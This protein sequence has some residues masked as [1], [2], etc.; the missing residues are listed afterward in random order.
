MTAVPKSDTSN[1]ERIV[2]SPPLDVVAGGDDVSYNLNGQKLGRK[3]RD[4]R[5]RILAACIQVLEDESDEQ[6][7]MSAVA[8][9]AQ[10]RMTSLYNYFADITELLL[11]V[12]EPVMTEAEDAFVASLRGYWPDDELA[13]RSAAFLEA[14][15]GF[16]SRN[17]RLLHWRN[18][19]ADGGDQRMLI[20]RVRATQPLILLLVAQMSGDPHDPDSPPVGMATVMMT[21][22]ERVTTVSTDRSLTGLF[23][24]NMR[25]RS[26]HYLKPLARVLELG[27]RDMRATMAG[28][29]PGG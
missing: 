12:L 26:D 17:A 2:R 14:Y 19:M 3:G 8:R 7:T 29:A 6:V 28:D 15:H 4:T 9:R 24:E 16:W 27:I 1:G 23:G 25:R 13:E 11:A 5:E 18:S 22:I 10:L 21:S 20:H